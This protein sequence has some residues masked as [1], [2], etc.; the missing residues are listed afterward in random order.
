MISDK[1]LAFIKKWEKLELHA[2]RDIAGIPTIGYGS[3]RH[4]DGSKVKLG[5]VIDELTAELLLRYECDDIAPKIDAMTLPD[6]TQCQ[7]DALISFCYNVGATAFRDSTLR[8]RINACAPNLEIRTQFMRWNKARIDG[9]LRPVRGL[10]RRRKAE[11]D[12]WEG[13]YEA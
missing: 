9:V 11:A 3:L 6:L 10:T 5:D 8:K 7:E 13:V 12:M 4:L 2:Y 1:G